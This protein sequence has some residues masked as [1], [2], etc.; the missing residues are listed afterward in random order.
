MPIVVKSKGLLPDLKDVAGDDKPISCFSS[1]RSQE[2]LIKD[3]NE[4]DF[5]RILPGEQVTFPDEGLTVAHTNGKHGKLEITEKKTLKHGERVRVSKDVEA[6]ML[7]DDLGGKHMFLV[8]NGFEISGVHPE[9]YLGH[10]VP[11]APGKK[12][13]EGEGRYYEELTLYHGSATQGIEKLDYAQDA[14]IGDGVYLTSQPIHALGYAFK[15]HKSAL[16][17]GDFKPPQ[18]YEVNLE[19][20]TFCDLRDSETVRGVMSDFGEYLRDNIET[21]TA[22]MKWN[23]KSAVRA[24]LKSLNPDRMAETNDLKKGLELLGRQF[25]DYMMGRGYD[26]I[27]AW[28]GGETHYVGTHDSFVLFNKGK[29]KKQTEY[30]HEEMMDRIVE[31]SKVA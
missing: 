26:G 7:E 31:L 3:L 29:I 11:G 25:N 10:P 8:K 17:R 9:I 27:I 1:P 18:I 2:D 19:D 24:G 22:D 23:Q 6:L 4:R 30:N 20:V 5:V 21:I 28:E 12:V 13:N 16:D 14:T 15:S